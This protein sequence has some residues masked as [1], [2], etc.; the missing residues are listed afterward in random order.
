MASIETNEPVSYTTFVTE[1]TDNT[2]EIRAASINGEDY[3][4]D[5]AGL[6]HRPVFLDKSPGPVML[7]SVSI[8]F[9]E[10]VEEVM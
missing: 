10:E 1:E 9:A 8:E 2:P 5:Y 4:F 6:K 7:A 3:K